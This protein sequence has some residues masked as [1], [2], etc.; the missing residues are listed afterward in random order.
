LEDGRDSRVRPS[1]KKGMEIQSEVG[2]GLKREVG[3]RQSQSPPPLPTP[4][5]PPPVRCKLVCIF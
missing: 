1:G 5:P 4:R 3:G 2:V